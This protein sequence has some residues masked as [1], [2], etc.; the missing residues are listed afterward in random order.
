MNELIYRATAD[1]VR[2]AADK[3]NEAFENL[4]DVL[5]D[6]YGENSKQAD[7]SLEVHNSFLEFVAPIIGA[8]ELEALS[9]ARV[10][11]RKGK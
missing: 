10:A 9:E 3:V 4:F 8:S 1:K 2:A 6:T 7:G 11:A 5:T